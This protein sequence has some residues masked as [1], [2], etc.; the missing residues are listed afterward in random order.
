M[1]ALVVPEVDIFVG[2]HS[3][4]LLYNGETPNGD[5]AWG[6]YPTIVEQPSGHRVS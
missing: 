3:H 1:A 2:A 4:S 6:P 5:N